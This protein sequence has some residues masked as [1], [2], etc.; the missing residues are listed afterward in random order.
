M[1]AGYGV[2]SQ[3]DGARMKYT[4]PPTQ[5]TKEAGK[6]GTIEF[7]GFGCAVVSQWEV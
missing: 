2:G 5:P 1:K 7:G 4:N 3:R 6:P